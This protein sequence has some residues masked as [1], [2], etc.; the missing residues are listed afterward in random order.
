MAALAQVQLAEERWRVGNPRYTQDLEALGWSS[1]E[2]PDGYY[3]LRVEHAD[4]A[5]FLVLARPA[6]VQQSD[7]C[8]VFA[9]GVDGPDHRN[10]YAGPGCW[11]R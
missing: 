6:G 10:G 5:A 3:H 4:A 1:P 7:R 9:M 8:G 11:R 2:S